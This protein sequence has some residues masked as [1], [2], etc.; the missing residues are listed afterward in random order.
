V[1]A[2]LPRTA[3]RTVVHLDGIGPPG[4]GPRAGGGSAW[5]AV[6]AWPRRHR[7]SADGRRHVASRPASRRRGYLRSRAGGRLPDGDSHPT[8]RV[9]SRAHER[10]SPGRPGS[11]TLPSTLGVSGRVPEDEAAPEEPTA[12]LPAGV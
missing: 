1:P 7:A 9:P 11:A 12:A 2:D 3:L 4:H 5:W 8:V 10:G 6:R